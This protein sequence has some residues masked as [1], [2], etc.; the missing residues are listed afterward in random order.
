M[1]G[2]LWNRLVRRVNADA[3]ER[4]AETGQMSPAERGIV[5]ESGEDRQAEAHAEEWLGGIDP[6]RL[7]GG[8]EPPRE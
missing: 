2:S 8:D 3:L 5:E 4:R 1:L 7:L 6:E